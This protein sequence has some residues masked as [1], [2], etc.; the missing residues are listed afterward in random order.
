MAS[1]H[2]RSGECLHERLLVKRHS[3]NPT[4][5]FAI[6]DEYVPGIL[7]VFAQSN[8]RPNAVESC[9]AMPCSCD[10]LF[11]PVKQ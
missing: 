11:S 6:S 1:V 2:C 8:I 4:G 5:E 3:G 10:P 7:V 9:T